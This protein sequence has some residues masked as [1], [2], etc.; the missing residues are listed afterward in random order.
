[1]EPPA[2]KPLLSKDDVSNKLEGFNVIKVLLND[3]KS[4]RVHVHGKF[5]DSEDDVIITLVKTPF[6]AESVEC[7]LSEDTTLKEEFNNDIYSQHSALTKPENNVITA[8]IIRP[9]TEKHL[10]KY[11]DQKLYLLNET[12]EDYKT[13]TLPY[14]E[15]QKF[16]LN[17]VYNI[18]DHKTETDRIVCEDPDKKTGFILLPDLKWDGKQTEDLYLVAIC[19]AVDIKSIRDLNRSHLPLLKNLL[20]KCLETI[21]DK[22]A[23][24]SDQIRAYF[25]YYPSYY[26]LHVHFNHIHHDVGGTSIGKAHLLS[27]VI[28]N[29]ENIDGE[30]YAKKTLPVTLRERDP[31]LPILTEKLSC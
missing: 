31:L 13:K 12:A 1:M 17:W 30:Y 2:K 22:Y 14:L 10:M 28:D 23:V 29:I 18:L 9:A 4:K 8:Q 6:S 16:S 25:H 24:A 19:H 5:E 27:D 15:T 11:L 3:V 20:N 21:K 7:V 26:H